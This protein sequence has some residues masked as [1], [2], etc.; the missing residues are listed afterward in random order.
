MCVNGPTHTN[1]SKSIDS[2]L[3]SGVANSIIEGVYIRIFVFTDHKNK[4]FQKKFVV[5]NT[6]LRIWTPLIIEFATP[7]ELYVG[8]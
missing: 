5:Q 7:L 3:N 2:E 4:R 6:N 1:L 8:N